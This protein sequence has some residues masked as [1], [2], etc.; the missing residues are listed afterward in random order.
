MITTLIFA[1]LISSSS[2]LPAHPLI[3]P[4]DNSASPESRP[5]IDERVFIQIG[6][7]QQSSI[8][9][10]RDAAP[11]LKQKM[12]Y[13]LG[14]LKGPMD[15]SPE[16]P[17]LEADV[18]LLSQILDDIEAKG[19]LPDIQ[20]EFDSV[21]SSFGGIKRAYGA[22][23]HPS[24]KPTGNPAPTTST[25]PRPIPVTTP[26]SQ[27]PPLDGMGGSQALPNIMLVVKIANPEP[28]Q[29]AYRIWYRP[30]NEIGLPAYTYTT[31]Q[32]K[33]LLTTIKREPNI[34]YYVWVNRFR[35]GDPR[36]G[37]V[38]ASETQLSARVIR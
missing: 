5:P 21:V 29:T 3:L 6:R 7:M 13:W 33:N 16:A 17:K 10:V 31:K 4:Q 14:G 34:N 20:V 25:P 18:K 32:G 1:T 19:L 35:E 36:R 2:G 11:G 27:V 15:Q 28:Y 9:T 12:Q 26:P 30:T 38:L 23:H 37:L 8:E 22:V 24:P